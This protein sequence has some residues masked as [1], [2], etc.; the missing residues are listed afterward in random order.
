MKVGAFSSA[1]GAFANSLRRQ[2]LW[3]VSKTVKESLENEQLSAS[4]L[5]RDINVF[6]VAI[7]PAEW[8]RRSV[9]GIPLADMPLR[10]VKT[11]LQQVVSVY[12][13]QV[14]DA[15]DEIDSAENSFVYQYLYRLASTPA[16]PGRAGA[17]SVGRPSTLLHR[18]S[19]S[20]VGS[21]AREPVAPEN[22][23]R[24][25]VMNGE[26]SS[27]VVGGSRGAED[28]EANQRLKEIFDLIGDPVKSRDVSA[29]VCRW[30]VPC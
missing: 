24:S 14:F 2:C 22:P 5:L 13:E 11:I 19:S 30:R 16:A 7:A 25:R 28:I 10:T 29:F 6:L 9:D 4:R 17:D 1:P 12:G 23:V 8:R 21:M 20:S 18:A 26:M 3:K 27:P 15:L